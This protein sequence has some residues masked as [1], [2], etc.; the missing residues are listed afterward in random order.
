MYNSSIRGQLNAIVYSTST[1]SGM[2]PNL[3]TLRFLQCLAQLKNNRRSF[4][5]SSSSN[6]AAGCNCSSQVMCS[7]RGS[8][9][10]PALHLTSRSV[11]LPAGTLILVTLSSNRLRVPRHTKRKVDFVSGE[12][13]D[14]T[15]STAMA[16]SVDIQTPDD[17][18]AVYGSI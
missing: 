12:R 18:G 1:C 16:G 15:A 11:P 14:T 6:I 3:I 4:C 9:L 2:S 7:S 5:D 10:V 8:H 13:P 17:A